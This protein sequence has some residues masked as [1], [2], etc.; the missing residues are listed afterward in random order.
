MTN[1]KTLV[2][3]LEVA[4]MTVYVWQLKDQYVNLKQLKTDWYVIAWGA[5]WLG[6]PPSKVIYRSQQDAKNPSDD[7]VILRELWKLIN[8]A[9]IVITQNGAKF[10]GPKLNARFILQGFKPPKPYKHHDVYKELRR[11]ASFTSHSLEYLTHRLCT[12]YKKLTERKFIGLSLWKACMVGDKRAWAEMKRYNVYDVLSTEELYLKTRM[13]TLESAPTP[14]LVD[15]ASKQCKVCGKKGHMTRRGVAVKN[16]FKYQ[17][18]QCQVCGSWC[19]GERI[20]S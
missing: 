2:L 17:R 8:E 1:L 19:T 9:D 5:K 4:P 3:D 15:K 12:R 10:D 11:V 16:K 6:E 20:K 13:W 18:W 14:Y 7:K